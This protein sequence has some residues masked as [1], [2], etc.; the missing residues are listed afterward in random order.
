MEKE[1]SAR[2]TVVL[3]DEELYRRLKVKAAQDGASMKDLVEEGLRRV[4]GD[5]SAR[6][7]EAKDFDWD[8]YE[9]MM[10]EWEAEDRALGIEPGDYP[11]DLSDIKRHLYG[12]PSASERRALRV[13][14]EKA[15]YSAK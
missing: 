3:D 11:A 9:A 6:A 7:G 5:S 14:D 2:L 12:H 10:E 8:R 1:M 15:P 13:A 4:L